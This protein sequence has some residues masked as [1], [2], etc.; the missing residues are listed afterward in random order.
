MLSKLHNITHSLAR[1]ALGVHKEHPP[2]GEDG[3]V[4]A[5]LVG[6]HH[7]FVGHQGSL[8]GQVTLHLSR[9]ELDAVLAQVVQ[10]FASF[11]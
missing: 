6:Q 8:G 11:A 1:D 7:R 3:H 10:N 5:A 2:G 4:P 9:V